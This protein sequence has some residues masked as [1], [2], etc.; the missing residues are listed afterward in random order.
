MFLREPT[1]LAFLD[2][3][4]F[5]ITGNLETETFTRERSIVRY[6]SFALLAKIFNRARCPT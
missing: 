4:K 2:E 5:E 1:P 3:S 6:I